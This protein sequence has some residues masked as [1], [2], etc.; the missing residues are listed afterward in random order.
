MLNW[1]KIRNR[2]TNGY[3][4]ECSHKPGKARSTQ[5]ISQLY[6]REKERIS[7]MNC[8]KRAM[9][10]ERNRLMDADE[11]GRYICLGRNSAMAFGK[12]IGAEIRIGRRVLFDR[13][14]VDQYF[15]SA[16]GVKR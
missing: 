6:Y 14:K 12:E 7:Q 9:P 11:L 2:I 4:K 13:V 8:R 1:R 10:D 5:K 15:D 3:K 16:T